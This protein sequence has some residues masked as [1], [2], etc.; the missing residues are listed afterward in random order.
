MP[1]PDFSD[2]IDL[3]VNDLQPTELYGAALD[4]A[5]TAFPEF[6]PRSGSVEEALLQAFA[7][8]NAVYIAAANRVPNGTVEGVLRLFGLERR[9][10]GVSTINAQFQILTPGGFVQEG[11]PVVYLTDEDGELLQY[12]FFVRETANAASFSNTVNV[13]LESLVLGP[14]PAIPVGT[15]L[16]IAQPSSELLSCITT[17]AP[18]SASSSE[19]DT[20][21]LTRGV[22][23][24]NSLSNSLC[25]ARQIEAYIVSTYPAVTRCKVFDLAYGSATAPVSS[26]TT[27]VSIEVPTLIDATISCADERDGLFAFSNSLGLF[28]DDK[29]AWITTQAS[30]GD[31]TVNR[32]TFPSGLVGVDA[33]YGFNSNTMIDNSLK[34]IDIQNAEVVNSQA[35]SNAGPTMFQTVG[36]LTWDQLD[37]PAKLREPDARG[38]YVIFVWGADNKPVEFD[39]V[40]TIYDDL[41]TRTPVG[42]DAFIHQVMPVEIFADIQIEILDGYVGSS[43]LADVQDNIQAYFSP[44]LYPNWTRNLYTNEIITRA[45]SAP[46]V[47]RVVS[48]VLS[49][50]EYGP[51]PITTTSGSQYRGNNFMASVI[52]TGVTFKTAGSM[53]QITANV[54]LYG[55]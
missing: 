16:T 48:V 49:I 33:T 6:E 28:L 11:T 39:I 53:P 41:A 24:L 51:A 36:G 35:I 2:Y 3:S 44:D 55:S 29:P 30:F 45:A 37:I 31:A 15:A 32:D 4:Y 34:Q 46:G 23:Y 20:E 19:S 13:V 27:A 21:Y 47:K 42:F 25:T 14:L 38:M 22:T 10:A 1:S 5:R 54:T 50:P 52:G 26:T 9:E 17:S 7:Y 8:V 43:V 18:S 12:S 40:N